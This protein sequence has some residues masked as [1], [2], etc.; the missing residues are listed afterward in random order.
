MDCCSTSLWNWATYRSL[1]P[2]GRAVGVGVAVGARVGVCS[3]VGVPAGVPGAAIVGG[4]VGGAGLGVGVACAVG[5]G[6]RVG[7][8]VMVG[9]G[10]L[11]RTSCVLPVVGSAET[12]IG[13]NS[14]AVSAAAV[15]SASAPNAIAPKNRIQAQRGIMDDCSRSARGCAGY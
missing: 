6:V 13:N 14:P 10:V 8:R 15:Q 4:S 7:R 3:G 12:S 1:G 2:D 5:V 9:V 11:A